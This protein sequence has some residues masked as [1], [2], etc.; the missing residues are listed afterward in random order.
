MILKLFFKNY[1][2]A[3]FHV[4]FSAGF[5]VSSAGFLIQKNTLFLGIF[6]GISTFL[7]YNIICFLKAKAYKKYPKKIWLQKNYKALLFLNI[8]GF[9]FWIFLLFN[10]PF[11]KI[12]KVLFLPFLL[13]F[14]YMIPLKLGN[15]NYYLRNIPFLKIFLIAFSWSWVAVVLP[16]EILN[17]EW[18]INYFCFFVQQF[19]FVFV[20]CLPF[21]I[22]DLKIDAKN[23]KTLPQILGVQKTKILGYFLAVFSFIFALKIWNTSYFLAVFWG[24]ILLVFSIF[25]AGKN[26]KYYCS[27]WVEGVPIFYYLFLLFAQIF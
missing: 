13:T 25:F 27:F 22:R 17:L 14:F 16:F 26:I 11:F 21:D 4:A 20:L 10:L 12:L 8:V 9:F 5:L 7:S 24:H 1:I 3:N 18:N 15:K 23:L 6:V 19:F 2:Y